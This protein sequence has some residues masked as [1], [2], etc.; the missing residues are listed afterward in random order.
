MGQL[1]DVRGKFH[2]AACRPGGVDRRGAMRSAEISLS[3]LRSSIEDAVRERLT[4]LIEALRA[5]DSADVAACC[6]WSA[7]LRDLAGL[8]E[9]H[10]LTEVAMHCFDCLDLIAID[11]A[12]MSGAEAACYADALAFAA[13]GQCSGRDLT[14][15]R[16]LLQDL[17]TLTGRIATRRVRQG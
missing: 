2:A 3:D 14:R 9:M 16:P 10:L 6:D 12:S 13:Q 17:G 1:V 5:W 4:P 8:A 15:Y 11:G 7:A